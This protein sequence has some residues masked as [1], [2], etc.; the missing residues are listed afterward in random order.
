M[1]EA[2]AAAATRKFSVDTLSAALIQYGKQALSI[3]D[4]GMKTCLLRTT[5]S[6]GKST[7]DG[8]ENAEARAGMPCDHVV[9]DLREPGLN[10]LVEVSVGDL[11]GLRPC[12]DQ[13]PDTVH[14]D[15]TGASASALEVDGRRLSCVRVGVAVA[16]APEQVGKAGHSGGFRSAVSDG[17]P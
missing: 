15:V 8:H 1:A 13:M 7:Q 5:R 16:S 3:V 2:E 10:L 4:G 14:V 11:A 12:A 17:L 6:A 9:R